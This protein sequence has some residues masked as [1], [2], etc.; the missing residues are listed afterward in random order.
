MRA[1]EFFLWILFKYVM[2]ESQIYFLIRQFLYLHFKFYPLSWFPERKPPTPFPSNCSPTHPLLL[3]CPGIPLHWGIGP[4]HDQGPLLSLMSNKAILCYI[5]S[6][7]HGYSLVGGL[8]PGS[9]GGTGWLILLFLQWGCKPLQLLRSFLQ[10][11]RWEPCKLQIYK[12]TIQALVT[13][14]VSK[15]L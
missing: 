14:L 4:S 7:S 13:C 11:L 3:P 15:V 2:W 12:I 10:L 5:C 8:L 1:E 9:S 6:W